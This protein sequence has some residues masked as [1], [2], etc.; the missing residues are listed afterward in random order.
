MISS[1]FGVE[2]RLVLETARIAWT[3]GCFCVIAML[4]SYLGRW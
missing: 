1:G 3:F 4:T 2:G